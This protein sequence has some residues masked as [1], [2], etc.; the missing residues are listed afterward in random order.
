MDLAKP[1]L[2]NQ[3]CLPNSLLTFKEFLLDYG[4]EEARKLGDNVLKL[5]LSGIRNAKIRDKTSQKLKD[6]EKGRR[7]LYF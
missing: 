7:D 1:G 3:F 5:H 2:I 6:L 4:D